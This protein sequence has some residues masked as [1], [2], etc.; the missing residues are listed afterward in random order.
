MFIGLRHGILSFGWGRRQLWRLIYL[1]LDSDEVLPEKHLLFPIHL[2]KIYYVIVWMKLN[3]QITL[4]KDLHWIKTKI[5]IWNNTRRLCFWCIYNKRLFFL[6]L[7]M[8]E[9]VCNFAQFLGCP[10]RMHLRGL[11]RLSCR[12]M[13]IPVTALGV[14]RAQ[15]P[16]LFTH[17]RFQHPHPLL[18][19]QTLT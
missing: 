10:H 18:W 7:K 12:A 15:N 13:W 8:D 5:W 11:K 2:G 19:L 3:S 1:L 17:R 9:R 6:R 14:F 4:Y 16:S